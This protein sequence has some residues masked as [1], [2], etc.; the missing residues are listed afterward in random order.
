IHGGPFD[1]FL[2]V[3]PING[4]RAKIYG[5]EIAWQQHLRFLPG[6]LSGIGIDA[7]YTYTNSKATF[8]PST[9][10]TG[11]ARLQRTTPNEYN[12][13]LT[14]DLGPFSMRAAVTYNAATIWEYQY[15]D[16]APG[17][18]QGPLGDI[19]LYPHTQV[20]LQAIYNLP[21][22]IALLF[23]ALNLSN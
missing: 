11:T 7:N 6:V 5:F 8:D 15:V 1:G 16:G 10:R 22:G 23:S 3:Q 13:G 9:G 12:A 2:K 14:Y 17:G 20:D 18:L 21:V 4:P 19:Y